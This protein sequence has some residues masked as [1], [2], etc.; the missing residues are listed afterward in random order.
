MT[1]PRVRLSWPAL[2][3]LASSE[4]EKFDTNVSNALDGLNGGAY[5]LLAALVL[6]RSSGAAAQAL[7]VTSRATLDRLEGHITSG[8]ELTVDGGG[9]LQVA[10]AGTLAA[11]DG[12]AVIIAA[13]IGAGGANLAILGRMNVGATGVVNFNGDSTTTFNGTF[14]HNAN[15][16]IGAFSTTSIITGASLLD[17]GTWVHAASHTFSGASAALVCTTSATAEFKT[18]TTTSFDSGSTLNLNGATV[19]GAAQPTPSTAP[20]VNNLYSTQV[21][22]AWASITTNGSGAVAVDDGFNIQ[23]VTF[24]TNDI[25]RVTF[26]TPLANATYHVDGQVDGDTPALFAAI[27]KG[28]TTVD[29]GIGTSVN[30]NSALNLT[31]NARTITFSITGRQ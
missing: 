1:F 24:F 6:G 23:G 14:G 9:V 10:N 7:H 3:V 20:G 30:T 18:S 22:K 17:A 5:S 15:L 31:T 27:A 16:N 12:A 2:S 28:L 19:L 11:L 25:I 4:M 29:I 8:L 21:C 13:D 26:V